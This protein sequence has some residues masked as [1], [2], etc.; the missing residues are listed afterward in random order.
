M[1]LTNTGTPDAPTPRAVRRFLAEFLSDRRVI[2]MPRWLWLPILHMVVLTTRPRRSA[3]LYQRIWTEQGSPLLET[4]HHQAKAI[5]RSLQAHTDARIII[6]AGMRYGSPSIADRLRSLHAQ[7][8]ERILVMPLFPQYSATTTAT[9]FDAV[10]AELNTWRS[11]PALRTISNYHHHPAYI[12]ALVESVQASWEIHDQPQRLLFSFHGLPESY[13]Q[14]GDPYPQQC[15]Q[16]ARLVAAQLGLP[17]DSWQVSYQSRFGSQVWLG[18]YTDETLAEWGRAG[19]KS[20][21]VICPGFS[22]DCLETLHEINIKARQIFMDAGGSD[23]A[24]IPA[25]NDHPSHIQAL[26]DI[27]TANLSGWLSDDHTG[28]EAQAAIRQ[29]VFN[30][31]FTA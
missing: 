25:L 5:H 23:F 13:A 26:S 14:A 8:A 4:A 3:R 22:G 29:E 17:G 18:P 15:R 31:V 11:M 6:A 28:Q 27:I 30:N 12:H 2:D 10:F 7:G 19:V 20:A 1:L 21:S 9:A 24:F 16:T